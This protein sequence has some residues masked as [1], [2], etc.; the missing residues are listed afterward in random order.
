MA[1]PHYDYSSDANMSQMRDD[2]ASG[3][4]DA[5]QAEVTADISRQAGAHGSGA[6]AR[7]ASPADSSSA[8]SV[9]DSLAHA[10]AADVEARAQELLSQPNTSAVPA[11]PD[12]G[13][14]WDAVPREVPTRP[15]ERDQ[16]RQRARD[17]I[18]KMLDEADRD[19]WMYE[20]PAVFGP[21]RPVQVRDRKGSGVGTT[22]ATL[23]A[24]EAAPAKAPWQDSAFNLESYQVDDA[25]PNWDGFDAAA[26]ERDDLVA[27]S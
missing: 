16:G 7:A 15:D 8:S 13:F 27:G 25:E 24:I 17:F 21:P 1:Q 4:L 20:M 5:S 11:R 9:A 3:Y 19:D 10:P 2:D 12:P 6:A 22:E 26:Y 18:A 14:G 23:E